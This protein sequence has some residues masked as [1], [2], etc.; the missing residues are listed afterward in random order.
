MAETHPGAGATPPGIETDSPSSAPAADVLTCPACSPEEGGA[1]Y[2][3]ILI[4]AGEIFAEL[5]YEGASMSHIAR[6]AGVSKGTLYNYF[7]NKAALFTAFVRQTSRNGLPNAF[8]SIRQ[9]LPLRGVLLGI[10]KGMI[11]LVIAPT[12]LM[13]Y[14]IVVSEA[15]RFPHLAQTFWENGP[16]I[17]I[18]TLSRWLQTQAANGHLDVPEPEFAAEQFFALCQTRIAMRC[19]L[20]M[21]VDTSPEEIERIATRS[22][23]MFLAVHVPH[24]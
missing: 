15:P 10:A 1:K 3:Q 19:R 8:Q 17:G 18:R 5:G 20:R 21:T 22:V 16:A 4:G 9:D 7:D 2:Q 24:T 6:R 14:R 13:L 12:T 23:D 11:G